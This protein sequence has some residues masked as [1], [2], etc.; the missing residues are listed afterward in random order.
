MEELVVAMAAAAR[1]QGATRVVIAGWT[2]GWPAHERQTWQALLQVP[3]VLS[4]EPDAVAATD[5][6]LWLGTAADGAAY[7]RQ[8]RT[9]NR[10][11][12]FWLG[13]AGADPVFV[14]HADSLDDVYWATWLDAAYEDWRRETQM[15]TAAYLVY[16]S[17]RWAVR[18]AIAAEGIAVPMDEMDRATEWRVYLWR[19]SAEG[20]SRPLGNSELQRKAH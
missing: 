16:W 3:V 17:T 7:L 9:A 15:S 20:T 11:A 19:F 2:P 13:P 18:A 8:L 6:V 10:D 12:A 5:A 14:E 4:D 1:E